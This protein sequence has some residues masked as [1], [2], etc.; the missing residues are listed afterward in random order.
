[1]MFRSDRHDA[2]QSKEFTITLLAARDSVGKA[3]LYNLCEEFLRLGTPLKLDIADTP[4]MV[5][6]EAT[7]P[8]LTE[9]L[10]ALCGG[11]GDNKNVRKITMPS[12]LRERSIG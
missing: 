6:L 2:A 7:F 8:S 5:G 9:E 11:L 10:E 1:M 4:E 3:F 12:G